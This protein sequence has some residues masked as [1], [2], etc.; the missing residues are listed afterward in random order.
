MVQRLADDFMVR[1][2]LEGETGGLELRYTGGRILL[3]PFSR[4]TVLALCSVAANARVVGLALMQAVH[5]MDLDAPPA[6]PAPV[7]PPIAASPLSALPP[8]AMKA[9]KRV[10]LDCVGPIGELLFTKIYAAW[11][12]EG[13]RPAELVQA[14]AAE[15]E[16]SA[17][18]KA[19]FRDARTIIG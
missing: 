2:S 1:Q 15:I 14:I 8:E 10:F 5:R 17:D 4:G 13:G 7:V 3:R 9:L 6:R 18:K 11:A 12:A 16:D 19:F